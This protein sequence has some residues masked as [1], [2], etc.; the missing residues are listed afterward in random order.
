MPLSCKI[1]VK[2]GP[3]VSAENSLHMKLALRVNVIVCG[4]IVNF[5]PKQVSQDL[6]DWFSQSLHQMKAFWVRMIDLDVF[7]LP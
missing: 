7:L 1:M 3:V 5:I 2:I 4:S 6:L